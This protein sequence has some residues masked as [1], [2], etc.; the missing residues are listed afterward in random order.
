MRYGSDYSAGDIKKPG[1]FSFGKMLLKDFSEE[2]TSII[3]SNR[4]VLYQG[5]KV[6]TF[7]LTEEKNSREAIGILKECIF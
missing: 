5:K 3:C 4:M 6:S 2:E 7:D 1:D